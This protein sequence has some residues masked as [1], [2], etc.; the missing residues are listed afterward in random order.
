MTRVDARFL[1]IIS[2][3]RPDLYRR[4]CADFA[5]VPHVAIILDRRMGGLTPV[6]E[7]RAITVREDLETLGWAIV[8]QRVAAGRR[9]S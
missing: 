6:H 9:A 8:P 1:Y 3:E 7:R 4:I 2:R 5:D